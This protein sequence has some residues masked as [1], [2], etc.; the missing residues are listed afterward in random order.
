MH[1]AGLTAQKD[2]IAL[3][4]AHRHEKQLQDAYDSSELAR[5]KF[6]NSLHEERQEL[7][8]CQEA[9]THERMR[10]EETDKNLNCVWNA[11]S[12]LVKIF[13]TIRCEVDAKDTSES[14]ESL[15][16][17]D[18]VLEIEAKVLRISELESTIEKEKRKNEADLCQRE[19]SLRL[20]AAQHAEDVFSQNKIIEGLDKS[21]RQL[22]SELEQIHN[23]KRR[24]R[25]GGRRRKQNIV[26]EDIP[27]IETHLN[28]K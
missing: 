19:E 23:V 22:Q 5:A 9:L 11:N 15:N 25:R 6:E 24:N 10:H 2:R 3:N 12:R 18:L 27:N 26:S 28:M 7:R 13:S 20:L 21:L 4:D 17:A 16:V 8:A 1:H 14:R